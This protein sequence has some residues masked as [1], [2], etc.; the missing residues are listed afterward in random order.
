[1]SVSSDRAVSLLRGQARWC[2]DLGSPLYSLL[3]ARA[4]QDAAE[5]GPTWR[6]LAPFDAPNARAD[7]LALRLMAAV[8]R[9][10]LTGQAP[11]LA[12]HYPSVG[13]S[14]G[15]GAADAFVEALGERAADLGPLIA[16]PCQTNEVGRSAALAFGYFELAGPGLPL[17]LLEVGASAGLNLR[18]DRY[19]YG[20]GGASWGP[21]QSPVDLAGLWLDAPPRLPLSIPILE[22]R[23]CDPRPVDLTR[24]EGRLD[25]E[26]SVWADQVARLER[27]RGA[28]DIAAHIPAQVDRASVVDWL[29]ARLAAPAK[30]TI[31]VVFHSIVEEYLSEAARLVFQRTLA[32]AGARAS[33]RAPIAWLRL[34][35]E[36]GSRRYDVK[37]TTWPGGDERVVARCSPHGADVRR[38]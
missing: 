10:V 37:L 16:R 5:G 23:G 27:L 6:L 20:G 12:V 17:R 18:F 35:P 26:S 8:H 3:L 15:P 31:T 22:R 2:A 33:A 36:R 38:G 11:R 30:D 21:P 34:E 28:L 29:P 9:L 19:H 24:K 14:A 13:G 1:V 7:S 25:L 4:A 32:E